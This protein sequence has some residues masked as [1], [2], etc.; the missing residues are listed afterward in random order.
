[1]TGPM[2]IDK[3]G[4]QA[5]AAGPRPWPQHIVVIVQRCAPPRYPADGANV[6]NDLQ[7]SHFYTR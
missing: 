6:A 2:I 3:A 1:M 5:A 7:L 4:D